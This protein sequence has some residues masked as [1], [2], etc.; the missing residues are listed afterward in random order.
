[1]YGNRV[2]ARPAAGDNTAGGPAGVTENAAAICDIAEGCI[3]RQAS[4]FFRS[5]DCSAGRKLSLTTGFL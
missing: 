3:A 2:P 1:M 4:V 5:G